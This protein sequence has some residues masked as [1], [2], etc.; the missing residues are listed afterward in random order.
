MVNGQTAGIGTSAA[1]C[2]SRGVL[3]GFDIING[4]HVVPSQSVYLS[5][6][7]RAAPKAPIIPAMSGR[8]ASQSAIFS[9]LLR[10]ALL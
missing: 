7:I 3:H 9:K 4:K 8:I 6:A 2:H 1:F 10:T 5:L